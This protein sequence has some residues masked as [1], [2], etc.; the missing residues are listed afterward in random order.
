MNLK[1]NHTMKYVLLFFISFAS[2]QVQGQGIVESVMDNNIKKV[3]FWLEQDCTLSNSSVDEHYSKIHIGNLIHLAAWKGE[4]EIIKLLVN[5]GVKMDDRN[6]N[7]DSPLMLASIWG[8]DETVN[9]LLSVGAYAN[10][11]NNDHLTPL[12]AAAAGGFNNIIKNLINHRADKNTRDKDGKTPENYATENDHTETVLL[13]RKL[14]PPKSQYEIVDSLN[15]EGSVEFSNNNFAKS[16][17]LFQKSLSISKTSEGYI[18]IAKIFLKNNDT[19]SA[20]ES[21]RSAI[22]LSY[23]DKGTNPRCELVHLLLLKDTLEHAETI[24][25]D[26]NCKEYNIQIAR[27]FY[28][29]KQ[30]KLALDYCWRE[31]NN[32]LNDSM[33][34][35]VALCYDALHDYN[36]AYKYYNKAKL[37]IGSI[38]DSTRKSRMDGIEHIYFPVIRFKI[39][40]IISTKDS[41][42]KNLRNI[43]PNT[44]K[45]YNNTKIGEYA[46]RNALEYIEGCEKV[47]DGFKKEFYD[48]EKIKIAM[49][50]LEYD[51][52]NS[53]NYNKRINP[54]SPVVKQGIKLKAII[55]LYHIINS[56]QNISSNEKDHII[57]IIKKNIN[58]Y[59]MQN[60]YVDN[61]TLAELFK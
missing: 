39:D 33:L 45:F 44:D 40:S 24:L 54:A 58:T 57:E 34:Y 52:D 42:L 9:Y 7:G 48:G 1:G 38:K 16:K 59:H 46:F 31:Y 43:D 27:N 30:Y 22:A 2:V 26:C 20:I 11:T 5:C 47:F 41:V 4:T 51:M 55:I 25:N 3:K 56:S 53:G 13:L 32:F 29:M 36:Q 49:T 10:A 37:I 18:G 35:S 17:I 6:A 28:R 23:G 21:Y 50:Q 61:K 19:I 14:S 8:K 15:N 60:L 12:H